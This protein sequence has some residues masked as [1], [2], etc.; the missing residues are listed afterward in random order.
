MARP[1]EMIATV[2]EASTLL[3]SVQGGTADW[4]IYLGK[5]PDKPDASITV[6]DSGG[7]PPNPQWLL[8]YPSV[9]IR[10]RG[11]SRD[12]EN[13]FLTAQKAKRALLGLVSQEV[14]GDQLV[15]I[16]MPGDIAFVGFDAKE[17]PEYVINLNLIIQPAVVAGENR[18]ALP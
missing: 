13:A 14:L 1:S 12:A 16:T 7:K 9:Q 18:E 15:S 3:S 11:D 4:A 6:Y 5:Q 8:D 10:V 2:L 17:R